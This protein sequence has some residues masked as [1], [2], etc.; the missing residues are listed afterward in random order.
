LWIVPGSITHLRVR[1]LDAESAVARR[2]NKAALGRE[3]FGSLRACTR[4]YARRKDSLALN[5]V[6]V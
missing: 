6:R 1:R 4:H 2:L 3:F 5:A